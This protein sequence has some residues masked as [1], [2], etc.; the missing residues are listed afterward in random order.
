MK[1]ESTKNVRRCVSMNF[2]L[3]ELLVVIAII[4]ILAAMLL[5]ALNTAKKLANSTLCLGN[6]KQLGLVYNTYCGD[7]NDSFPPGDWDKQ[8]YVQMTIDS[9]NSRYPNGLLRDYLEPN[10]GPGYILYCPSADEAH[11]HAD[12]A[13]DYFVNPATNG[14]C[15]SS[16]HWHEANKRLGSKFYTAEDCIFHPPPLDYAKRPEQVELVRDILTQWTVNNNFVIPHLNAINM[17][18]IDGHGETVKCNVSPVYCAPFLV[19][20]TPF[21]GV[22]LYGASDPH[23]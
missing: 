15:D 12:S 11:Y 18:F 23:L 17:V 4:A 7:Y 2:T 8:H 6:L 1:D 5:P 19:W 10:Y 3:V 13:P 22:W 16:G 14:D 21:D 20:G 9:S